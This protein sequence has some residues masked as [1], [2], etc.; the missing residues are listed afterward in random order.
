MT[1]TS[2]F[3]KI[4][5]RTW[6]A[7]AIVTA[8][9]AVPAGLMAWGPDRP[10]Y[11]MAHPAD[12]VTFNSITDNPAHGDER[13]FVQVR[14][15]TDN[16]QFTE[17]VTLT[18]GKEYEV[19]VFYHNNAATRLN[20]AAH[21]YAGIA[22][23]AFIRTDLPAS[24]AAGSDARING[25]VGASNA[26]PQQVWDEAYAKNS[27]S[28]A[29][30]LRIVPGSAK[31]TSN[32]AV[33]GKSLPDTLYTTGTPLGYSALDGKVPGCA[34]YSGYVTYRFKAD[35]PNFTVEKTVSKQ[36]AG[37]YNENVATNPGDLV[38]FRI[39]YKNTG[40]TQQDA[41]VIRDQLPANMTYVANSTY[42]SNSS[43][44][45]AW[46]AITANTVTQQGI[47]IG[48]YAPGGAGYVKF[49]AKV[50]SKDAL[51]CGTNNLVNT[52]SADTQ[53]GSKSDTASVTVTKECQPE[54]VKACNLKTFKIE[55]V[56]KSKIDNVNYTLDLSKCE[57]KK[58]QACNLK[59]F[60]IETVEESK[61]DNV[62]YTLDLKKCEVKKVEACNLKTMKIETV[63]ES[64]IDNVNYTLDL[65]KCKKPEMVKACN[66]KTMK[67]ETVEKSKIDG[68]NYTTDLTKC[69]VKKVKA[70]NLETLKIETVEESK[71]DNVK[72]TLDLSK[73]EK[74]PETVQACDLKTKEIVT[75]EK[76]K[77]D[78]VNY[79]LDLTKCEEETT[80]QVCDLET[81][82]IVTV[83]ESEASND[84]Y[85]TDLSK[86]EKTPE[87]PTELPHTGAA[88]GILSVLGLGSIV[89]VASAYIASR[90][91]GQN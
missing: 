22:K 12:H 19:Y 76:S 13:N 14:N 84:R 35:Q 59:T 30:A 3:R 78:N 75:V 31:I 51:A 81:K 80:V 46:K 18:P 67:I 79:T 40:T 29:I 88:E 77:I 42:V 62:N 2:L 43:T 7:A 60:K 1:L 53:N 65:E 48:S 4:S 38:D 58:V 91:L 68:V 90:R 6:A 82:Q 87:T 41:V 8:V 86:C 10:T 57:V 32:G 61:I 89:G 15:V 11:T 25:Y 49:T 72:Y 44:G 47:N 55:T 39:K 34:E 74:K 73:C 36:G 63:E 54:K 85:T 70:C 69:E 52:A 28:A 5:K 71:I 45:N 26:S 27:T 64:K 83:K 66:L 33:N 21:N 24:V 37:Q 50:A 20:D 56:E 9:V 17:N 23:D 16:G